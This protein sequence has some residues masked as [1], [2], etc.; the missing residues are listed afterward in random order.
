MAGPSENDELLTT[1]SIKIPRWVEDEFMRI[2]HD[3]GLDF[4]KAGRIALMEIA[5]HFQKHWKRGPA[6]SPFL[7]H[8]EFQAEQYN[9]F[10]E[11]K[12]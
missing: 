11:R 5:R 6:L 12:Q 9:I 8:L 7:E 2:C 3:T 1:V 4:S 10:F